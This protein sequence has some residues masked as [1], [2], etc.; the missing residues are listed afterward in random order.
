MTIQ[1]YEDLEVWKNARELCKKLMELVNNSSLGKDYSIKDQILRSSGSVMDN[2]AEGFERDGRKE[3]IQFLYISKGSL[4]ETRSQIH[5][6]FDAGHISETKYEELTD[7]CLRLSG[8]LS[9]F[10]TYLHKT[11]IQGLKK[12][13]P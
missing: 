1:K 5:R 7:D 6:T 8:Q 13:S 10:I 11:E 12:K 2:I 9:N 3:F 4:G